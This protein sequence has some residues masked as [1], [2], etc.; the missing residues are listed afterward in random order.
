M[1]LD[2][3]QSAIIAAFVRPRIKTYI[4]KNKKI[5]QE[6]LTKQLQ[7]RHEPLKLEKSKH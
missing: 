3:S 7:A 6:W 2:S 1:K 5:Y 4:E